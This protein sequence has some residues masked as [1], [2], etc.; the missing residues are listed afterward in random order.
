ML[1]S[2][3]CLVKYGKADGKRV[4]LVHKE[5]SWGGLRGSRY[6]EFP[7]LYPTKAFA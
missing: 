3:M 7:P 1:L 4:I 2:I 5:I 6:A